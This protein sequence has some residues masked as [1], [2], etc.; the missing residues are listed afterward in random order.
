MSEDSLAQHAS[1]FTSRGAKLFDQGLINSK[2]I[3]S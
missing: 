3:E 2:D 1:D